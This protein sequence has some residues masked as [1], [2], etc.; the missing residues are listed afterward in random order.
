MMV[1]IQIPLIQILLTQIPLI[2]KKAKTHPSV[3]DA[4]CLHLLISFLTTI[5]YYCCEYLVI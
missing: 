3:Y 5:I 2:Q 1:L 4:S